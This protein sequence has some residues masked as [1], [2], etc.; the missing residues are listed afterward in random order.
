MRPR[1]WQE[2]MTRVAHLPSLVPV[3][4]GLWMLCPYALSETACFGATTIAS[5]ITSAFISLEQLLRARLATSGLVGQC[6]PRK[7]INVLEVAG[8][9]G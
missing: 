2:P 4:F 3:Y 9:L 6:P 7:A 8:H 5:A 1:L